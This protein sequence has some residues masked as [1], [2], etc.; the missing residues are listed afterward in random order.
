MK[1]NYLEAL[2]IDQKQAN[3]GEE[4]TLGERNII[5]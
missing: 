2:E 4:V 5:L 3:T 1:N